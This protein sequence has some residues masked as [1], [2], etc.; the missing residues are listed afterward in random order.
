MLLKV[1]IMGSR[2]AL[3]LIARLELINFDAVPRSGGAIVVSNHLGRLDAMLGV[4]LLGSVGRNDL[5]V[6]VAEKY[7]QYAIWR[8][9]A[10]Q[11]NGIWLNRFEVDLRAMRQ[12]HKR[13]RQGEMLAMAPEGTRSETEAMAAGKPGAAFLA[14]KTGLP[15][16]PVGLTG[17]ED[18]GVKT[19]LKRLRR[20]DIT[21]RIGEPFILPPMSGNDRDAYLHEQTEE[22]MCRIAALLPPKYR[23]F[24]AEHPR[25][26]ELLSDGKSGMSGLSPRDKR[27]QA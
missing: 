11:L 9:F 19:R 7:Q 1:I 5:I 15:L 21:I 27:A 14:Y 25:L 13:L 24:Y 6:M 16:V 12:V 26:Q 18:R 8:W 17:T 3:R 2:L 22:I 10:R 20:L 23:G 4:L